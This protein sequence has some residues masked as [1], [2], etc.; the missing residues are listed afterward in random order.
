MTIPRILTVAVLSIASSTAAWARQDGT[1]PPQDP[2]RGRGDGP[3]GER[4]RG[5]IDPAQAIERIMQ[6]DADGD[7]VLSKDELPPQLADRLMER[8]DANK[9]GSIDRAELEAAFKSGALG[10]GG[11]G[12]RGGEGRG[13]EGAPPPGAPGNV[14]GAMRQL[15]RAFRTLSSSGFDAASRRADLGSVQALQSSLIAAKS[16]GMNLRMSEA[17]KAKFGD[18][19]ERFEVEFRTAMLE[20]L[21]IS[22]DLERALLAGDG[23][24]AKSLL[25]KLKAEQE[26]GHELFQ[27]AEGEGA[28]EGEGMREGEG[29]APEQPPQRPRGSRGRPSGEG[30]QGRP[31]GGA[32]GNGD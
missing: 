31:R 4:P 32:P 12:G 13:G 26:K 11:A 14:E 25:E 2:P 16:A 21:T 3:Q 6:N 9:D 18:D 8:G 20:S 27:P 22:I 17:A 7:G 1:F 10:R 24:R 30:P 29:N 28:R 5:P 15:N 23:A 19:R